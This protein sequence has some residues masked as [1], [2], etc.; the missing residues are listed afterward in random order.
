M[1]RKTKDDATVLTFLQE[2]ESVKAEEGGRY[3]GR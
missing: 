1:E 2:Q 3:A